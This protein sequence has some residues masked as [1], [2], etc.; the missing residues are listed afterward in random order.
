M[1]RS[2]NY[3]DVAAVWGHQA[4]R[5]LDKILHKSLIINGTPDWVRTSDI[6]LRRRVLYPT[7]L[8][9]LYLFSMSYG[10]TIMLQTWL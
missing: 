8:Q 3:R 5:Q 9:A 10:V 1:N 6:P 4:N 2:P 7:E